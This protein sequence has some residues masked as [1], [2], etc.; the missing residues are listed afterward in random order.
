MASTRRSVLAALLASP[1]LAMTGINFAAAQPTLGL[2]L[3]PDC[4]DG[5][6][7][8]VPQTEGPYFK[9]SAPLKRNLAA[10]APRGERMTIGGLVCFGV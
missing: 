6:E 1:A 3:T 5:D 9:P 8:T 2:D 7:H 10:D 4:H